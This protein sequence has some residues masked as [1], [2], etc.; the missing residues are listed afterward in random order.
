MAGR[1]VLVLGAE[2]QPLLCQRLR[3]AGYEPLGAPLEGGV[4]RYLDEA[5]PDLILLPAAAGAADATRVLQERASVP[6]VWVIDQASRELVEEAGACGVA[7][8]VR[9]G[10]DSLELA[11][12]LEVARRAF[13]SREELRRTVARLEEALATRKLVERAKGLLM[14][15]HGLAEAEAYHRLRRLAMSSRRPLRE[16]AELVIGL[17]DPDSRSREPRRET[18]KG[19]SR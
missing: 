11:L 7:A 4:E 3:Q 13:A 6:V 1:R 9:A 10:A 19:A 17:V 14:E 5:R 2:G 12:T 8:V 15:R 18:P 16:V